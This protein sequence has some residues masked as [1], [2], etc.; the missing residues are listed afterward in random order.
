[1]AKRSSNT[2]TTQKHRVHEP[3]PNPSREG[4]QQDADERSLPPLGRRR[5]HRHLVMHCCWKTL[6]FSLSPW[7]TNGERVGERGF[8]FGPTTLLSPALSSLGGR[9]G[10][11]QMIAPGT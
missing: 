3:T 11:R 1:M 6:D 10:R 4:N 5:G 7:G 9:R 8:R 2:R